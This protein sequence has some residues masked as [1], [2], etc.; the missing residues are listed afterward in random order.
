MGERPNKNGGKN[1]LAS[2]KSPYLLQH[3]DNPVDWYPWGEEA[4]AAAKQ[5]DRPIFLSIGYATCHWCHV[6]AHESF[7]NSE[8]AGILNENF[9]C[10][11]VDREERPDVDQVYMAACQALN[12]SGGWPLSAFLDFTGRPFFVGTYFPPKPRRGMPGFADLCLQIAALWKND[13][14]KLLSAGSSIVQAISPQAGNAHELDMAVASKARQQLGRAFDAAHGG[15]GTAP[16]FPTPHNLLFLVAFDQLVE[17]GRDSQAL[18]MVEKTLWAMYRGGIWDHLG[19]GIARYSVDEKWLVPHFEKMLYD[20]ALVALAAI[21]AWA[22][23]KKPFLREMAC[24]IFTFVLGQMTSRDGG[25]YCAFDADSQGVEGLYYVWTPAQVEEVLDSQSARLFCRYFRVSQEGNFENGWSI[26]NAP[27]KIEDFAR[28]EGLEVSAAQSLLEKARIK[29]LEARFRREP[30]LLD[31][32]VLTSWNGLMIAAL[33]RAALV[34]DEPDYLAAAKRAV[35][36]VFDNLTD[37]NGLLLRRFRENQARHTGFLDDYAFFVWGLIE[38]YQAGGDPAYLEKALA[39]HKK[40][41]ELFGSESGGLYYTPSHGETLVARIQDAY[42]GALPSGNSV[43]AA[44]GI[45]LARLV[46]DSSLEEQARGILNAF[47]AAAAAQPTAFTHL[48]HALVAAQGNLREVVLCG[49]FRQEGYKALAGAF[50]GRY[51]GGLSLLQC[52]PGEAGRALAQIAPFVGPMLEAADSPKA[53][54]CQD[55]ACQAPVD[56]ASA[57]AQLLDDRQGRA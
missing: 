21:D 33:A 2:E 50:S 26:L 1:R 31:D 57:L 45:R 9:I 25:F 49:D 51:L 38:L 52:Q 44:N 34:F 29:L 41:F 11:K 18:E 36:F 23:I 46:G 20:Q 28:L 42:D 37:E 47:G 53:F 5:L 56:D 10:V 43:A 8:V 55:N 3:A 30:P 16:K 40:S 27:M 6:M 32:K 15:F 19:F 54:V 39:L 35:D 12:R 4:F 48:L 22:V 7:E 14:N 13:R 17:A 24:K